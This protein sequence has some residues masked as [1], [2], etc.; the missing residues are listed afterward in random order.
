MI[1]SVRMLCC[2][3]IA[4]LL[5]SSVPYDP[6]IGPTFSSS[7]VD[8][9]YPGTWREIESV[10]FRNLTYSLN[11]AR[12]VLKDGASRNRDEV[13]YSEASLQRGYLLRSSTSG[14]PDA[15][16]VLL[17]WSSAGGSSSSGDAAFVLV[18]R[19]GRLHLIQVM[20]SDTHFQTAE[21]FTTFDEAT[22]T[23]VFRSA[24]YIPGDAH[25]CVSAMDV[26]T[27]R[28]DGSAFVQSSFVTELSEYGKSE[29]RQLPH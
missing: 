4:T 20:N 3:A 29:H 25:C 24:H 5:A 10:D 11:G 18:L 6:G 8:Q 17:S 14:K 16:L 15:A 21:P 13:G 9:L 2:L 19:D 28:W 26:V 22:K 7:R 27:L 23:L 12:W 1:R